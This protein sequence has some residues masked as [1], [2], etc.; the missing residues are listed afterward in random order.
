MSGMKSQKK[1]LGVIL[2]SI[3]TGSAL[4]LWTSLASEADRAGVSLYVFPGGRLDSMPDSEYLRNSVYRLAN[5]EN[6]DALISWGSSIGGAV[7]IE[8]LDSFHASLD[9]LPYVTI[10][11][12]MKGHPC[13]RFDAYTGMKSLVTHFIRVHGARKIAFIRGPSSHASAEDRYRAYRDALSDAGIACADASP[14]ISDPFPWSEGGSAA[15]QFFEERRL[16]PGQDFDTLIGTSDMMVFS[17]VQYLQKSGFSVPRDYRCAGFNNSSESRILSSPLSTVHMPYAEIGVSAFKMVRTLLA[18]EDTADCTLPATVVLRE[19]CGCRKNLNVSPSPRNTLACAPGV[20]TERLF[21]RLAELFH[22]DETGQNAVLQPVLSA[23]SCEDSDLFFNLLE[24]V[25][26]RF[27]D[28]DRETSL[29]FDCI[30]LIKGSGC[31]SVA[32]LESLE[33][34]VLRAITRI[35]SRVLA[36]K[37]YETGTLYAILNSLKCD[38]LCARDRKSLMSILSKH[39]PQA[40]IHSA[41][42]ALC[43]NDG[44]S[45]FIGGFSP[46][47][48]YSE[49][50]ELFP[51]KHLLPSHLKDN[52]EN[53]VFLVQPL[54]MENQPLGYVVC[55]V[56]FLDGTVFEELR[57]A[58]SSAL[59]GIFLFEETIAAKQKAEQ[60]ERA[61]TEFF[62]NVGIDLCDPLSEIADSLVQMEGELGGMQNASAPD[63]R[64]IADRVNQLQSLVAAQTQRT[65]RLIDLT[66]SQINELTFKKRLFSIQ[67]VL[68]SSLASRLDGYPLLH[69]DPFRLT[70]AFSC[71][72]ENCREGI[73]ISLTS[74][75]LFLTF[76]SFSPLSPPIWE[77]NEMLLAE[78]IILLQ[79]G[80]F[81]RELSA[82]SVLLPWPDLAGLP[83][84]KDA[85]T[86]SR[87][88]DLSGDLPL[89]SFGIPVQAISRDESL[90]QFGSS[91]ENLLLAWNP[92]TAS[93]SDWIRVYALR[94][95][96]KLF[97]AS[98]LCYGRDFAGESLIGTIENAVREKKL[99]PILFIGEPGDSY[100]L[101]AGAENSIRI[102]SMADFASAVSEIPPCLIVFAKIDI[103]AIQEVRLNPATVL[104]PL[105]VLPEKIS[106]EEEVS[107]LSAQSHIILCNSNIASSPEFALRVRAILSGEEILPPHTGALV[108]KAILYFNRHAS[109]QIARW[110]LADS[111]NVSEDYLTRIFH[112]E[113]GL[114]LWEYLNSYRIFLADGLLLRTNDSIYEIAQL[115]GFQDQ[116]Y[117]C[118]VFKKIHGFP[119]G[120]LRTKN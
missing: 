23:L 6:L 22:L 33:R 75:G 98:F 93:L 2:A 35:Q 11:H 94:H 72:I 116:A 102:P 15:L 62:A 88:L 29:L 50:S 44:Y 9:P 65:N 28:A 117:F 1:R 106:T 66:L 105:L 36:L 96:P 97:R 113:I 64:V 16:I 58:V 55:S 47:G 17:A 13:V 30:N 86:V 67:E 73:E 32:F 70:E 51:S 90:S 24:R 63:M 81:R 49:E 19:S 21:L 18:G 110:K 53:G 83:P 7:P 85:C 20:E 10:A 3:H 59:K 52:F 99:G 101:W 118:R 4:N 77:K 95:H 115:T 40:G 112:K 107:S 109:S 42:I 82:C 39:L 41:A 104:V 114:S 45:R 69:G 46:S 8:E 5:E 12:K 120:K 103:S 27:F 108:K 91:G 119:P 68:P 54:Y 31:F 100:G 61:K 57:S 71:I 56:P 80:D 84:L 74:A 78:K 14:L 37:R 34:P 60:A 76:T 92:D 43:E 48:E 25:L 26:D 89:S 87:I 111:V 79:Y 38:L